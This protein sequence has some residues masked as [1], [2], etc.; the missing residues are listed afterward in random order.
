MSKTLAGK[1]VVITGGTTGIGLATAQLFHAQG[2][3]VLVT[4]RNEKTLA[5]ARESL[6]EGI[7]IFKSEA[8]SLSD[9]D[10]LVAR[11]KELFGGVDVLFLN[12][13]VARFA[14]LELVPESEWDDMVG[15]NAKGPYF[16]VQKF[17]PLL[18]E[19]ASIVVNTSVVDVKGFPSTS[20]YSASKAA[21]RSLVRTFAAELAPR[22]IRVNAVSPGPITTP[23]YGKLGLDAATAADFAKNTMESNP[24]KRFGTPDEVA[25]AALFLASPASSYTTGLDLPVD[26]GASQL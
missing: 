4:G 18:A 1:R 5:E 23:I 14:P 6:P 26:G 13:G 11:T 10:A 24:M 7:E 19:G 8:G 15:I 25:Q 16:T 22:G 17:L 21:L 2:A 12:A 9:I 3:R 20:V